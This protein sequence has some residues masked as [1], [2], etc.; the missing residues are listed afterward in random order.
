MSKLMSISLLTVAM[1]V[2]SGCGNVNNAWCPPEKPA[3]PAVKQ[4]TLTLSADA[5]FKFDQFTLKGLLPADRE[6]LD[7]FVRKLKE[8]AG[9]IESLAVV[10]HT[11]RLGSDTYNDTLGL[12]R[13]ETVKTLLQDEGVTVPVNAESMGKRQPVTVN[14]EGKDAAL[15]ACLQPDRRVD[16]T[17][18]YK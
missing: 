7:T 5:L 8:N 14:C 6:K 16:I 13:A 1:S 2:L 12:K 18:T 11:D 4:E 9:R 3:E 10:G 17:V 15:K